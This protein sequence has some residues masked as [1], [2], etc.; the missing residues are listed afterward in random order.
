MNEGSF[1]CT[2]RKNLSKVLAWGT[3]NK[4]MGLQPTPILFEWSLKKIRILHLFLNKWDNVVHFHKEQNYNVYD[5]G[6]F[7]FHSIKSYY[8]ITL[9][10]ISQF[11]PKNSRSHRKWNFS[12]NVTFLP[13]PPKIR[14]TIQ[15]NPS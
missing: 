4:T 8:F 7:I 9:N 11:H 5:K 3:K 12:P 1:I 15:W 6:M 14:N 13:N 2:V 10:N